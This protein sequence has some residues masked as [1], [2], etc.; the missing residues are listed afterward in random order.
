MAEGVVIGLII[1]AILFAMV[2]FVVILNSAERR[3]PVQYSKKMQ[4]RKLVGGQQ[5]KIPLKVNTAGVIPIIFA[6]SIR[7][8]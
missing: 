3:I 5:S 2:V 1:V 6:S 4:G 8:V 7:C